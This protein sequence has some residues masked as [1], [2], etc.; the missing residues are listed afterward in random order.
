MWSC[1]IWT[2]KCYM[3][4]CDFQNDKYC[5]RKLDDICLLWVNQSSN[6]KVLCTLCWR[7]RVQRKA[8]H[9]GLQMYP[10][11]TYFCPSEGNF[12]T[13]VVVMDLCPS[14]VI[15]LRDWAVKHLKNIT[16]AQWVFMLS[17]LSLWS[18]C[19]CVCRGCCWPLHQLWCSTLV[20]PSTTLVHRVASV[21]FFAVLH[22]STRMFFSDKI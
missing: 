12:Q 14:G 19:L 21:S 1:C 8:R 7:N 11:H 16:E 18:L 17:V 4:P 9:N 15:I 2:I 10:P 13:G 6:N 22:E 20:Y 3:R 5:L